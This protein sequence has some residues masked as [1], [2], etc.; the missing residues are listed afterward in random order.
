MNRANQVR[1]MMLRLGKIAQRSGVAIVAVRHLRKAGAKNALHAGVG[2]IDYIAAAR[3]VLIV[4]RHGD[5]TILAHAKCNLALPG[6]S[7]AYLIDDSGFQWIGKVDVG[8][9]DLTSGSQEAGSPGA[10]EQ[11]KAFLKEALKGGP[12]QAKEVQDWAEDEGISG[13]TLKRAKKD[14]GIKS[15]QESKKWFW[16][17]PDLE[18]ATE[19]TGEAQEASRR[20]DAPLTP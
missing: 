3:S 7:L 4:G 1:Q 5:K 17:L 19:H 18:A 10:R 16:T 15:H 6:P 12:V 8:A 20:T 11:A 9:D 2:S 14:L 13:K